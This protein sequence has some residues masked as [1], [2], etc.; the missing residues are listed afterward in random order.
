MAG[1]R[2]AGVKRCL[3]PQERREYIDG[4]AF[5]KPRERCLDCRAVRQ[6]R[7][8]FKP[9][10]VDVARHSQVRWGPWVSAGEQVKAALVAQNAGRLENGYL[11]FDMPDLEKGQ[12]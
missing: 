12:K 5:G 7:I 6:K 4:G 11:V 3:H 8:V 2:H 1:D 9:Q 10:T